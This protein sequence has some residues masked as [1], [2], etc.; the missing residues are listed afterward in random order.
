M[1]HARYRR[2]MSTA[3]CG[4]EVPCVEPFTIQKTRVQNPSRYKQPVCR[5]LYDTNKPCAE[6]FTIQTPRVQSPLQYIQPAC[7]NLYGTNNPC[8]E[9]F[10]VQTTRVKN[11]LPNSSPCTEPFTIQT[12]RVYRGT[13]CT[14]CTEEPRVRRV[15]GNH[16]ENARQYRLSA[17]TALYHTDRMCAKPSTIQTACE[18]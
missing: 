8:A 5:T 18:K 17:C 7:R 15:Q 16:V 2:P 11:P 12:E 1:S 3:S 10:T 9:P 6:P 14:V 4:T 13:T